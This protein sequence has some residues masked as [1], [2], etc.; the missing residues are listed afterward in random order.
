MQFAGKTLFLE[1]FNELLLTFGEA[2]NRSTTLV[3]FVVIKSLSA[4]NAIMG[5][6]ILNALRTTTST[7][8]LMTKFPA[9]GEGEGVGSVL[10][11]QYKSRQ[12]YAIALCNKYIHL[13]GFP[14][15]LELSSENAS[16]RGTK[17]LT[18]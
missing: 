3:N 6:L 16:S 11:D 10:G 9:E 15:F 1:G 12:C 5:R 7:Y 17:N 4:Y 2:P 14:I 18:T 8:H 13:E